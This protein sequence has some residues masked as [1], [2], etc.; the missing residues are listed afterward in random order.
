VNLDGNPLTIYDNAVPQCNG[1]LAITDYD[2]DF[3]SWTVGANYSFTDTMSSYVRANRGGHFSDFDNGIRGS[4]TG[5][6]PPIQ[7]VRNYEIGFKFQNEFLYADLSGY[8]RDFTGLQY[9]QTDRLG[10]PT[11]AKLFYGSESK[12]VNF[13]GALTLWDNFRFQA[14][15][16]YLDGEYTD[17]DACVPF[18]NV[19]TGD[20]C[21]R[22]EGQQLQRQPKL[23][24]ML[25]PSYHFPFDWG[26]I[27]AQVTYTHVGDRT[28][29]QSGLQ[30]LGSYYTWDFALIANVGDNWQFALRGT[31]ISDELALTESNSRIFGTAAGTNGVLLARPL[32]GSEINF[33]AKYLW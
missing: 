33:Q 6:T 16:N 15:A 2:K 29:D 4:V 1:T 28:Q 32:E 10:A 12:G 11:G 30:Q 19:V 7:V 5:E 9:Q 31:N 3:T 24:Y 21:A 27:D 8:Y 23:R 13:I 17:Y 18:T 20:G 25:T 14:V 22:I 26:G